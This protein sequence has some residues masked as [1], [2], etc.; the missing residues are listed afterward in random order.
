MTLSGCRI[1]FVCGDEWRGDT[2]VKDH[3]DEWRKS[4]LAKDHVSRD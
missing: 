1:P 3:G 4:P 2:L